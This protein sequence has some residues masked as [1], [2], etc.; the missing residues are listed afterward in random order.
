[1]YSRVVFPLC[2]PSLHD[3]Q[4][5]WKVSWTASSTGSPSAEG[6]WYTLPYI[7]VL[8]SQWWRHESWP[9]LHLRQR[10]QQSS[11]LPCVELIRTC[12]SNMEA[13]WTGSQ[14][15]LAQLLPG[16][17]VSSSSISCFYTFG[18]LYSPTNIVN[19]LL[20]GLWQMHCISPIC[21]LTYCRHTSLLMFISKVISYF[22]DGK[23]DFF[24]KLTTAMVPTTPS[25]RLILRR[26]AI[27]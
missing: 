1:M 22:K 13:G 12:I 15:L 11:G 27:K 18:Y 24:L 17:N 26:N 14:H 4:H 3:G 8:W 5:F 6:E 16:E 20:I 25:V 2:S 7:P 19:I 9:A 21:D 23:A 10:E